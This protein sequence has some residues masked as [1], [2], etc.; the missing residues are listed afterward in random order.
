MGCT[1]KSAKVAEREQEYMGSNLAFTFPQREFRK[2]VYTYSKTDCYSE[3]SLQVCHCGWAKMTTYQ[4]LRIHQGKMGCTPKGMKTPKREEYDR[5][6]QWEVKEVQ[7]QHET[8][9]RT[10]K[11][12]VTIRDSSITVG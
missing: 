9:K 10:I 6:H 1:L 3:L 8:T 2:D 7:I 4:G 5:K 12:E 11:K